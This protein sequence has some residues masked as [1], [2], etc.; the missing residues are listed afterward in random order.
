MM[1]IN[2]IKCYLVLFL[3]IFS[4]LINCSS[5]SAFNAVAKKGNARLPHYCQG[6]EPWASIPYNYKPG[7]TI[8]SG[9]CGVCALAMIVSG[10]TGQDVT[11]KVMLDHINE[12]GV[13]KYAT[14]SG[15]TEGL[16][17]SF[18][19]KWGVD[20]KVIDDSTKSI[21]S[22]IDS[23]CLLYFC[24][25][26][27]GTYNGDGHYLVCYGREPKKKGY[28]MIDSSPVY[29]VDEWYKYKNA[30]G[31]AVGDIYA[32]S[33]GNG[34]AAGGTDATGQD[35]ATTM[36]QAGSTGVADY[37]AKTEW[38]LE[39]MGGAGLKRE[40]D[41]FNVDLPTKDSLSKD[42]QQ[43]M[44]TI[45]E[46]IIYNNTKKPIVFMRA[47]LAAL[48]IVLCIYAV[49]LY[50]AYWLDRLNNFFEFHLLSMLT[51]GR[52]DISPDDKTS[53]FRHSGKGSK[54]RIV[55]HRDMVYIV[56]LLITASMLVLSGAAFSYLQAL[57]S[58]IGHILSNTGSAV[59]G[60]L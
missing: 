5:V 48:A 23:G 17:A 13:D 51:L 25:V 4:V 54:T 37:F 7:G 1:G 60:V 8:K 29:K 2:R 35:G 11:P 12:M 52:L 36:A 6:E 19:E 20:Y 3:F 15:D 38:E 55:V 53:T 42:I 43:W 39:G 40:F 33:G 28:Y 31:G 24:T 27:N 14:V 47:F 41:D 16:L 56:V 46:D 44:E 30:F 22:A 59:G 50:F 9:G 45:Q 26:A 49:F 57:I 34:E 18:K 10:L 32:L 21:N 58:L